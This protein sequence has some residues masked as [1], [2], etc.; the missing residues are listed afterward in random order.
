MRRIAIISATILLAAAGGVGLGYQLAGNHKVLAEQD[1]APLKNIYPFLDPSVYEDNQHQEIIDFDPLRQNIT[2]YL[3]S[4]SVS[5]SF[6]FEYLPNGVTIRD[7]EDSFSQA[8]SLMKTPL[9]MDLYKL[10]EQGKISLSDKETIEP[11]DIDTD[12][13]Y[14]NP[15]HL[16][17]GQTISL[18][19]AAQITLNDSDNTTLNIIKSVI[20]PLV[21]QTSDSFRYLDL[22]YSVGGLA[23]NAQITISARSY[24]SILTCLYFACLN[25]PEDSTNILKYLTNSAEPN[26]LAAGVGSGT[27]VAH[28]VGSAG[29][30]AQSD[31]GIV[32]YPQ[33]PYL[34]CLMLFNIPSTNTNVDPYFQ[35]LSQMTYD[36]IKSTS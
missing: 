23:N 34:I 18:S 8:A 32:Y 7:D 1:P 13:V 27:L 26:R 3:Q 4:L 29:S 10:A 31:C 36:Y 21:D 11:V 33:K 35:H 20:L 28:K 22:D 12:P 15:T 9:V 5:Y 14:G 24:S 6:Y 19:Q 2:A 25:S 30:T 16:E 17:T